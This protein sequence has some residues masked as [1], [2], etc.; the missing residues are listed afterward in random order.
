MSVDNS[1]QF[2]KLETY[3]KY[4]NEKGILMEAVWLAFIYQK[5]HP[6]W[7]VSGCFEHAIWNVMANEAKRE[8]K[9]DRSATIAKIQELEK[10][11][12]N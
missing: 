6:D 2:D 7:E 5:H 9:Y 10:I 4:C 12:D 8:L 1:D 3:L 11:K